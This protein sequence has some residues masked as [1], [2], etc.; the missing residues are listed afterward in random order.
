MQRA[1][2]LFFVNTNRNGRSCSSFTSLAIRTPPGTCPLARPSRR[3]NTLYGCALSIVSDRLWPRRFVQCVGSDPSTYVPLATHRASGSVFSGLTLSLAACA[4]CRNF[5]QHR[6]HVFIGARP[7]PTTANAA[8]HYH[9][10]RHLAVLFVAADLDSGAC[11]AANEA[12]GTCCTVL[13][14]C[15]APRVVSL[16]AHDFTDVPPCRRTDSHHHHRSRSPSRVSSGHPRQRRSLSRRRSRSLT[17]SR[18]PT[19]TATRTRARTRVGPAAASR[20]HPSR[21]RC[22]CRRS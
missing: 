5:S 22:R 12:A 8:A 1:V 3:A 19:T 13:G 11:A 18:L 7:R 6:E 17:S 15:S 21:S 4:V 20:L 14:P 2:L 10:E 16:I 9:H